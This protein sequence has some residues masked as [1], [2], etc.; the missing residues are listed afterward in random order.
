MAKLS[1]QELSLIAE[2]ARSMLRRSRDPGDLSAS[3]RAGGM[4]YFVVGALPMAARYRGVRSLLAASA[5]K[6]ASS[7]RTA[8]AA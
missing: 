8:P 7:R 4:R 5:S 3:S 1:A 2:M 6:A